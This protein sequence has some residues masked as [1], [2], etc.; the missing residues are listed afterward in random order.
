MESDVKYIT[1]DAMQSQSSVERKRKHWQIYQH[2]NR[3]EA[4]F[5]M[6]SEGADQQTDTLQETQNPTCT[7]ARNPKSS[8]K[9][10][11]FA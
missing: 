7:G 2:I 11:W 4:K 5:R 8:F 10:T 3:T 9:D 6:N 1:F